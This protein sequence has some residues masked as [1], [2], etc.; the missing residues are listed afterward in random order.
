MLVRA[1]IEAGT[2]TVLDGFAWCVIYWP[3]I[4]NAGRWTLAWKATST[5]I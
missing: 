5:Y 1:R 2:N 3:S 4:A